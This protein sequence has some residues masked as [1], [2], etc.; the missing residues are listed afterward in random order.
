M[1]RTQSLLFGFYLDALRMEEVVD[2]CRTA[3]VTR[4]RLLVG[5]VNAAK[6][7]KVRSDPLLCNAL[8][9]CDLLLADGQSV[10]WASRLLGRPLPERVTG[11]DLFEALLALAHTDN[12]SIYLLGAT[13]QVVTTLREE[14]GRRFPGL[15]IAGAR[16]G[17]FKDHEAAD[18]AAGIKAAAPD[19]LFLGMT[20]PKKELF[21]A[22]Y[23]S[24]L[25]VPVLHGVGGSFDILAGMTRR[26]PETWQ[27]AGMEWAYRVLQ[28]PGR[29]WW[30]YMTTNTAFVALTIREL[31]RPMHAYRP[32]G[33]GMARGR[34]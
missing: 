33:V 20:S 10:V 4:N 2:R 7:V 32:N 21:L 18:I 3:I 13:P 27:R 26:A 29:L 9:Q 22:R 24:S 34:A 19:M 12:K 15:R 23:G 11:I 6:L 8:T 5:V 1:A 25:D 14:L 16:D 31:I 17:Y 28:E 30:R